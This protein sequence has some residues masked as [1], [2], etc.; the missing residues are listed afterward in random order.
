MSHMQ[1]PPCMTA[2]PQSVNTLSVPA[3]THTT[4]LTPRSASGLA[5]MDI[6]SSHRQPET[7]TCYNCGKPGHISPQ[8][9]EPW[10]E[11]VH[12]NIID[13]A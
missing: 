12:A 2:T 5:P 7:H 1:P 11:R 6:N 13:A 4:L 9:P 10:K 3:T 8:F